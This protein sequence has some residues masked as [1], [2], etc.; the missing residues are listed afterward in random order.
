MKKLCILLL[1]LILAGCSTNLTAENTNKELVTVCRQ[2]S[3]RMSDV[4]STEDG[5]YELF[6]HTDGTAEI[7]FTDLSTGIRKPLQTENPI[8]TP[9]G[10]MNGMFIAGDKI[11][12]YSYAYPESM[13]IEYRPGILYQYS[14][15]GKL[16]NSV[17]MDEAVVLDMGSAVVYDGKHIYI[18]GEDMNT[19]NDTLCLYSINTVSMGVEK[20][21]SFDESIMRLD[22][23]YKNSLIFEAMTH[24]D[25]KPDY[26]IMILDMDTM[27]MKTLFTP[28]SSMVQLGEKLFF[29]HNKKNINATY[30]VTTRNYGKMKFFDDS[31]GINIMFL[32]RTAEADGKL[33]IKTRQGEELKDYVYDFN[34]GKTSQVNWYYYDMPYF[35]DGKDTDYFLVPIAKEDHPLQELP[36]NA[37]DRKFAII[38]AE[39]YYNGKDNLMYVKNEINYH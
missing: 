3:A 23:C 37:R 19:G 24:N 22:G 30:D 13:N 5:W 36:V 32:S 6:K 29:E 38:T 26:C 27:E 12:H 35:L 10:I 7:L 17:E 33:L 25:N 28:E 4:Q 21:Y 2:V 11:Y 34:T 18:T 9:Y 20:I 14:T 31:S 39:D 15:D 1:A 16:M 8:V